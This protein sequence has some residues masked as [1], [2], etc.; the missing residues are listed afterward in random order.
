[1][2]RGGRWRAPPP[3][4]EPRWLP[5]P[6]ASPPAGGPAP[7]G[8]PGGSHHAQ[9]LPLSSVSTRRSRSAAAWVNHAR[10]AASSGVQEKRRYPPEL[11]SRPIGSSDSHRA[12]KLT[13]APASLLDRGLAHRHPHA[14]L[15][16]ELGS[17]L[18][19]AP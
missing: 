6:T 11:P 17:L 7:P 10:H 9:R 15:G 3:G 2:A 5:V 4:T 12:A 1:G 19:T 14:P 16:R 13:T 18:V 8:A